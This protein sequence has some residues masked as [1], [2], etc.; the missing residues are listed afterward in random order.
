MKKIMILL[1]SFVLLLSIPSLP[2][3]E[4]VKMSDL[5]RLPDRAN[6]YLVKPRYKRYPRS[7]SS[8]GIWF[9]NVLVIA[10]NGYH[11]NDI[12]EATPIFASKPNFMIRYSPTI[13][14]PKLPG[15]CA[16]RIRDDATYVL[17]KLQ[18]QTKICRVSGNYINCDNRF[19]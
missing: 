10:K 18:N 16:K 13:C 7:R 17:F 6:W 14:G 19:P 9:Y 4:R 1:S 11:A 2:G 5:K 15:K 12:V 8:S 3:Q